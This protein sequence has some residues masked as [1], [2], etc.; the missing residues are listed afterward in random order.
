LTFRTSKKHKAQ[1]STKSSKNALKLASKFQKFLNT[2]IA[3][4]KD[5]KEVDERFVLQ[6]SQQSDR[7][8]TLLDQLKEVVPENRGRSILGQTCELWAK[9]VA[10]LGSKDNLGYS[11]L[12]GPEG[13]SDDTQG[14]L[15]EAVVDTET[16][17]FQMLYAFK[18]SLSVLVQT[19]DSVEQRDCSDVFSSSKEIIESVQSRQRML[20]KIAGSKR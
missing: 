10:S 1:E 19:P 18:T 9:W 3:S 7:I 14:I 20:A 11:S 5:L 8:L 13:S 6:L 12:K 16:H 4:K 17:V 2:G 15:L